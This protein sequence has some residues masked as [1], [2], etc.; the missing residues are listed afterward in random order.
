M[1]TI[2]RTNSQSQDFTDLVKLLDADLKVR[3]GEDNA[4]YSQFNKLDLIK[5]VV[6][7]Y[8]GDRP[9]GC[10]AI[11][12][13]QP[14]KI[15]VKRMYVT[16]EGR[17]RGIATIMLNELENWAKELGY[18]YCILETGKKQPEAIALYKKSGYQIIENYGPYAGVANSVCF[19][20]QILQE[21]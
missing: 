13:Y 14:E 15:E 3:D 17:G 6:V 7:A 8:D 20:K 9:I 11:R 16:P 1:I 12:E 10:G 19:E 4:F 18:E 2:L 21:K 5:H